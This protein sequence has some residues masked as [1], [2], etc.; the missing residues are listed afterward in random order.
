[1]LIRPPGSTKNTLLQHGCPLFMGKFFPRESGNIKP[2]L[3]AQ[4]GERIKK[5]GVVAR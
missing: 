4:A 3:T 2:V 1:M 5:R